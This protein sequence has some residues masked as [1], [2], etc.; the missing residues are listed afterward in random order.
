MSN[1]PVEN[2]IAIHC[3]NEPTT[4]CFG[5]D[6]SLTEDDTATEVLTRDNGYQF[7]GDCCI[8][9]YIVGEN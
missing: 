7:V 8:E 4:I 1:C 3:N 9:D 5:C 6:E 2:E